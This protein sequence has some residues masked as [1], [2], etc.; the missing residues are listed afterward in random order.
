MNVLPVLLTSE[1]LIVFLAFHL[2]KMRNVPSQAQKETMF[3]SSR[4]EKRD[5]IFLSNIIV[6]AECYIVV[7]LKWS[8]FSKRNTYRGCY[9]QFFGYLEDKIVQIMLGTSWISLGKMAEALS[10]EVMRDNCVLLNLEEWGTIF[11]ASV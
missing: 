9:G 7:P 6:F 3:F 11:A 4:K 2:C 8:G 5:I 10:C 1:W